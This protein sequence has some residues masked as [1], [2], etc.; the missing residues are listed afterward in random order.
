MPVTVTIA[1]SNGAGEPNL[2]VQGG[3]ADE[4]LAPGD[5]TQVEISGGDNISL[6]ETTEGKS[7]P[8]D[9]AG[10]DQPGADEG[11]DS[12]A[13]GETNDSDGGTDDGERTEQQAA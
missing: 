6:T 12:A 9:P 13:E 4:I 7:E 3:A 2:R 8:A 1:N 10:D 11:G 5:S